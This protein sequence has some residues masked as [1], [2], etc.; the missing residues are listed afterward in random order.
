MTDDAKAKKTD[1][2]LPLS[3]TE[4]TPEPVAE[5]KPTEEEAAILRGKQRQEAILRVRKQSPVDLTVGRN[6]WADSRKEAVHIYAPECEDTKEYNESLKRFVV[7]KRGT[8]TPYYAPKE[9][10]ARTVNRGYVPKTDEHGKFVCDDGGDILFTRDRSISDADMARAVEQSNIRLRASHN[11]NVSDD[12]A[13]GN[14][15]VTD[16]E[17]KVELIQGG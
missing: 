2:E 16:D 8:H 15:R 9:A 14:G 10:L 11:E 13:D 17:T 3:K 7:V 5:K 4:Q 12:S 6:T 1:T